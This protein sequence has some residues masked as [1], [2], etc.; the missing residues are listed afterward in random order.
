V[1]RSTRT[2]SRLAWASWACTLAFALAGVALLARFRSARGSERQQLKW[3]AYAGSIL[4]VVFLARIAVTASVRF[5]WLPPARAASL[6]GPLG[7]LV[8]LALT[9]MPVATGIAILTYRLY[10]I[11]RIINRT[12]VYG[13]LTA[14]LGLGYAATVIVLSQPAGGRRSGLAVAGATLAMAALV[15]PVRRRIQQAIDRRFNRRKYDAAQTIEAFAG[16]MRQQVD[17]D[18]LAAEVLA[19][20]VQTMQ[21][22]HVSLWLRPREPSPKGLPE[23]APGMTAPAS[24]VRAGRSPTLEPRPRALEAAR[25]PAQAGLRAAKRTR[26]GMVATLGPARP[27]ACRRPGRVPGSTTTIVSNRWMRRNFQLGR[28][29]VPARTPPGRSTRAASASSRSCKA[30]EGTW[31]SMVKQTTALK[32]PSANG[33]AVPSPCTTSTE[34]PSSRP[35]RAARRPSTSS[36]VRPGTRRAKSRVVTP[37]PGPTSSTSGPRSTPSRAQGRSV[38]STY[39]AHPGEAQ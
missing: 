8:L 36:A 2:A 19:V 23:H 1:I 32:L 39:L 7:V 9:G 18:T 20:V 6:L 34:P 25:D 10:D 38:V 17:L 27:A 21:P 33:M 5:G 37:R 14:V 4:A 29:S 30:G 3:L 26:P 24:L 35:R 15:R 12:L 31:W 16:R 13:L 22:T 28:L 11:D